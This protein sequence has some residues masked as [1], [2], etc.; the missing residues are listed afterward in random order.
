MGP[1]SVSFLLSS[2]LPTC[3]SQ[4]WAHPPHQPV[5]CRP[6]ERAQ[7]SREGQGWTGQSAGPAQETSGSS[8]STSRSETGAHCWLWGRLSI[9]RPPLFV[10]PKFE[11]GSVL[12]T[13]P[14]SCPH[15]ST[16]SCF[17]ATSPEPSL[18]QTPQGATECQ[19][20][21]HGLSREHRG[22]PA[23]T[24]TA[25]ALGEAGFCTGV[26][27]G[28]LPGTRWQPRGQRAFPWTLAPHS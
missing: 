4:P 13:R 16:T 11:A 6:W 2:S 23:N 1:E 21:A 20:R 17:P 5:R 12:P 25:A 14:G 3:V 18:A 28:S 26:G 15:A 19:H 8:V 24:R 10:A 22:R 9:L 7:L 27:W